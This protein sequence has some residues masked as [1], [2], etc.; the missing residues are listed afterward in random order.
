MKR[1]IENIMT[2]TGAVLILLAFFAEIFGAKFIYT[3]TFFEILGANTLIHLGL[4][5]TQKYESRY[6]I[7]EFLLDITYTIAVLIVF[8]LIFNWYANMPVWVLL[9]MAVVIYIFGF[10]INTMRTREDAK[11]M[12][13]LLQ[14]RKKKHTNIASW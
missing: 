7:L 11:E 6:V 14:K 2:T 8:G 12:D 9:V 4:L 3:R 5:L 10:L 1:T 13:D